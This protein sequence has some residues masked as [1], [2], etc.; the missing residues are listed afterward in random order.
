VDHSNHPKNNLRTLKHEKICYGIY[1][2]IKNIKIAVRLSWLQNIL[3][4]KMMAMHHALL[5]LTTTY[6]DKPTHIFTY[7][8][9]VLSLFN[10]QISKHIINNNHLDKIVLESMVQ[11]L[12]SCT[13]TT[14]LHKVRAHT[15]IKGIEEDTLAKW[16]C[17]LDHKNAEAPPEHAYPTP[18]YLQKD[19]W[20]SMQ[21]ILDKGP[22]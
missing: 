21:E 3:R 5:L 4:A 17:K 20:H 12:Q 1:S 18:Y 10:T 22:I 6:K 8:L 16:G 15:N 2:P 7:C 13:Q 9:D 19:R 11:V 14:T